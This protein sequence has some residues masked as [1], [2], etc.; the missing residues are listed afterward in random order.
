MKYIYDIN[1][2]FNEDYFDFFDW[3]REDSIIHIKKIPIFKINSNALKEIKNNN[4]E[5]DQTFLNLIYNKTEYF[6]NHSIKKYMYACLFTDLKSVIGVKIEDKVYY[7]SLQISDELDIL[8]DI[9]LEKINLNYKIVGKANRLNLKTRKQYDKELKLKKCLQ[10]LI[11]EK[12]EEKIKY[13]YYECFNEKEDN[14]DKIID[15]INKEK[16]NKEISLKLIN[17]FNLNR[18]IN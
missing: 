7:S 9:K 1:I 18:Q 6:N 10:K 14:I 15:K 3:N 17:F 11:I 5:L 13:L 4:I 16:Q 8:E 12:N 2:N